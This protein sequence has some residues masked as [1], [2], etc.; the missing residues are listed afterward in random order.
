VLLRIEKVDS[1]CALEVPGYAVC[2]A[3]LWWNATSGS[4]APGTRLAT[5]VN[6]TA[7]PGCEPPPGG[8]CLVRGNVTLRH[9][10]GGPGEETE[11]RLSLTARLD[12]APPG[13]DGD[14]ELDARFVVRTEPASAA[15]A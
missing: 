15:D 11:W 8:T 5:A 1:G 12:G 2:D 7:G 4:A 13:A 14:F 9:A 6:G 3:T 10:F